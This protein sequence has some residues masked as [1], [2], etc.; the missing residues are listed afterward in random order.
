MWYPDDVQRLRALSDLVAGWVSERVHLPW[1]LSGR[2]GS[3]RPATPTT[4]ELPDLMPGYRL[5]IADPDRQRRSRPIPGE[6]DR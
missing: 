6:T 1:D 3:R 5:S 2:G 4:V